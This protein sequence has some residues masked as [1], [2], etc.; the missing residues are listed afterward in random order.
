MLDKGWV[1]LYRCIFEKAIWTSSTPEQKVILITL[2]SM[3]N[4]EQREWE[5]QGKQFKAIPGQFVTSLDSIL[6]KAG[7][8]ISQQNVR[9]ALTKFKKYEF[10]TEEVTKTGRLITIV[11]WGVYQTG[12]KETNKA[13]NKDL[14]KTSQTPNKHLTTNKNDK[15][16]KNDK[17]YIYISEFTENKKLL[18]AIID[19]M[20]MRDSIKKPMTDKAIKLMLGKLNK[21]SEVEEIQIKI[22]ERS[23]LNNWSDIYELKEGNNGNGVYG[24][25]SNTGQAKK[26]NVK[27]PK[28]VELTDEERR[29][30]DEELL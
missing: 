20:K 8:G 22:L 11:N 30:A 2:L 23:I 19:F 7:K 27:P 3:A 4:H 10:L 17:K 28:T 24:T 13:T 18:E 15:N 1:K 29:R 14:T 25:K 26:Y 12:E 5:W 21:Y 9:T 6:I 16:Y